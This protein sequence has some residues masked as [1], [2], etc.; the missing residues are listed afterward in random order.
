MQRPG[1]AVDH[2]QADI[3]RRIGELIPEAGP[4]A[5]RT[6]ER[7]VADVGDDALAGE[8]GAGLD[9]EIL[10]LVVADQPPAA[11]FLQGL[12][13]DEAACAAAEFD[14]RRGAQRFDRVDDVEEETRVGL[15]AAEVGQRVGG[16]FEPV[17]QR[18]LLVLAAA[19]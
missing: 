1:W 11:I 19:P 17:Q 2:E 5:R 4:V 15:P 12:A 7:C 9:D 3:G 16:Q 6:P 14:H 13:D 10:M 8:P 18:R